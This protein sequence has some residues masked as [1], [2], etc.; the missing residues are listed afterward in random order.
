MKAKR[1][2]TEARDSNIDSN[3]QDVKRSLT[4]SF[5]YFFTK[6]NFLSQ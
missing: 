6:I 2:Y 1:I 3:I 5:E 4:T